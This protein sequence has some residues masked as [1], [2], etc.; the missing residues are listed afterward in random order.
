MSEVYH[1]FSLTRIYQLVIGFYPYTNNTKYWQQLDNAVP[2][3]RYIVLKLTADS[4]DACS[5]VVSER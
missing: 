1:H 4:H 3:F 2:Y 5:E